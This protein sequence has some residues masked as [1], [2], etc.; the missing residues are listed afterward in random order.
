MN[1][2]LKNLIKSLS[3]PHFK[4]LV[5]HFCKAKF[6]AD[7]VRIVDGPYDGG[8]DL[9]I[10]IGDKDIKQNVQVTINKSYERK[11][12]ADLCKIS[13][14][15]NRNQQLDFFISQ[16]LT[17][18]KR[19]SLETDARINHNISLRI[20]DANIL[21][22]EPLDIVR[23]KVYE[24]HNIDVHTSIEVDKNTKI[25]FDV[26]TLGKDSVEVKKNFFASLIL[27]CIYN[28]PHIKYT[29]LKEILKP[30]LK[31][32][33]DEEYLKKEINNLKQKQIVLSPSTDKWEFYLSEEKQQ[34]INKIY[35]E[36]DLLEKVLLQDVREYIRTN[37]IP[38]SEQ[39]LCQTIKSFYYKNYKITI[40]DLTKNN[41]STFQSVKKTYADLI[42][43][44]AKKGCG[45]D[46]SNKY[47][48]GVLRAIQNNAYLNKIAVATLF[49]N[50][51]NDDKLQLYINKQNKSILLDTQILIRLLCVIYEEDYDYEDT[52]IHAVGI[53]YRTLNKFQR[54]TYVYTT[55]EYV[56]EVAA[57]IQD[58]LKLQRFLDL[59]YKNLF[60]RSKNVFY[61]A[62]INLLNA[63]LINSNWTL[64][65][66]ICDL[67]A[68]EPQNLPSYQDTYFNKYIVD[69]LT[70]IYEHSDL[71][72]DVLD[73]PNANNSSQIKKEY[74][75]MLLTTNRDR[76]PLAIDNDVKAIL[77]LY[78]DFQ[79]NNEKSFIVSWDFAFVDIRKRLDTTNKNYSNWYVFT[80]L[81]MVDRLSIMNYSINP[82]SIS[83]D[84][85][86]LAENNFNYTT[87][88]KSF[89]DFISSFFN[90][91][92]V[93][94]HAIIKKLAQLNQD[95]TPKVSDEEAEFEEESQ[96][97]KM[98]LDI[99]DHYRKNFSRY[100]LEN[101][102]TTFGDNTI[103]DEI[104][105]I[106]RQYLSEKTIDKQQLFTNIDSLIEQTTTVS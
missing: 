55:R 17:K 20:Y 66:F 14:L 5:I 50:L 1:T 25:L 96:F 94:N 22:Q 41:E 80:P 19:D 77:H 88:T 79:A 52:A 98:L 69:K 8:N 28:N 48:E 67:I 44:F 36:C 23:E 57:H 45:N 11:L 32:K 35:Q 84:V 21:S 64:E 70:F 47:A 102:I 58:A 31:N 4:D 56:S 2:E 40:E 99:H 30:Q 18:T 85:I 3:E 81:K 97:V 101:L 27:S 13:S 89:F 60:G 46:D 7:S 34:E 12:E 43:F 78:E 24:Y 87:H 10:I 63:N 93:K 103:S 83:L 26:L 68:V 6:N 54:N 104:I 9:E 74:E 95:L 91:A 29:N 37:K 59:P 49:T 39:E 73:S 105:N 51:Y 75:T 100:N 106:F 92:D 90:D 86:A 42:N 15:P 61:N 76:S 71:K 16:E 65:D 53:L 62:Y 38:C 33:I 72:I 82:S